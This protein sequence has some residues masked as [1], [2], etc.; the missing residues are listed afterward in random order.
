[1]FTSIQES[2]QGCVICAVGLIVVVL[3]K[4]PSSPQINFLAKIKFFSNRSQYITPFT[5]PSMM[6]TICRVESSLY[7]I[8]NFSFICL[9]LLTMGIVKKAALQEYVLIQDKV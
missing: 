3:L 4:Y 7:N 9:A 1:M 5:I 2:T 8:F 6:S